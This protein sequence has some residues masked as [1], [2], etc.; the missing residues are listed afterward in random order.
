MSVHSSTPPEPAPGATPS[1]TPNQR[2]WNRR[3]MSRYDLFVVHGTYR[4]L[5]GCPHPR[6]GALY[7]AAVRPGATMLEVGPGAGYF[8]DRLNPDD[9]DLH[10]LD[11]HDGPLE[12]TAARLARYTPTTHRHD[13]LQPFPLQ[14]GSVDVV[15]M[16]MV[17]H[18]LPGSSIAEKAPVFDNI[19]AVLK[20]TSGTFIGATVLRHGAGLSA[21]GRAGLRY[22]NAK[23]AF[24]NSGDSLTDLSRV[25]HDRFTDVRLAVCGS[26]ALWQVKAK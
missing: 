17:L 15:S 24:R 22:L 10:L 25:L 23:D 12:T 8:L 18:C 3:I 11:I 6:V 9:L 13:A 21:I 26:V 2:M 20:P 19:A 4:F 14:P 1:A 5:W 7:S 16:S